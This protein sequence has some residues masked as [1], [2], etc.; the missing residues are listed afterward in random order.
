[1]ESTISFIIGLHAFSGLTAL[2]TGFIAILSRKGEKL[3]RACGKLF[4]YAMLLVCA[5]AL[6]VSIYKS[7]LF[8][9]FIGFFS[10]YQNLSG[11]RAIKNKSRNP[12]WFDWVLVAIGATNGL[13]MLF[14]GNPVLMVFGGISLLLV[15]GDIRIYATVLRGREIAKMAWLRQHIGMMMG[16]YIA[17]STAFIVVNVTYSAAPWVPWLLPT[18]I[19]VPILIY[20]SRKFAPTQKAAKS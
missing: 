8:L 3:H 1:M 11:Y 2:V 13:L 20:M 12:A 4:F 15:F 14:T 7:N 5:T 6:F 9:L 16:T 19:G 18:F 17:T 10:L